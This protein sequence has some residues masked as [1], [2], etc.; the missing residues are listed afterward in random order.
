MNKGALIEVR[1]SMGAVLTEEDKRFLKRMKICP[2]KKPPPR[3]DELNLTPED[4]AIL[5]SLFVA[6]A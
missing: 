3:E 6:S 4:I 5:Q 2:Y 1:A